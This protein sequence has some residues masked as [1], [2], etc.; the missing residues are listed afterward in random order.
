M[1]QELV[2][3]TPAD[4]SSYPRRVLL[5]VSGL[6]PQIVTETLYA[7]ATQSPTPW[8]PTEIHLLTTT[9]GAHRARLS[10]LSDDLGWF[11]RLCRDYGLQGITF[12]TDHIHVLQ[13]A[14]GEAMEDIR[15]VQDNSAAADAITAQVRAFSA[16]T[17]S[18]LHVSIAGG[19]K[20]MGF[21]AGYALSLF[22]RPQDR[23]SHVLVSEP[24]ENTLDFFYPT[25]YSR[26]LQTLNGRYADTREAQVTLAHIPFVSLR[27]GLPDA[28]LQGSATFNETVD[29]ARMALA[30]PKLSI[31]IRNRA[32]EAGGRKVR[33][34]PASLAM[35]ALFARRAMQQLPPIAAPHKEVPDME[36][37]EH[38]LPDFLRCS[39]G[40]FA[41]AEATK[42][43]LKH[44]MDGRW[45]STNLTRL[46]KT[47]KKALGPA[48]AAYCIDDGGSR[49]RR[50]SLRLPGNSISFSD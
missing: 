41:S 6:S 30:P 5:A 36:W 17:Q 28:L 24:F 8:V 11:H 40:D 42:Q 13:T 7:L 4:P 48:A 32:I 33:L 14:S 46:H 10:L 18:A 23:L 20:S 22:G 45:F 29:A 1:Q 12:N 25:P 15:T 37:A 27:H 49:P 21:Y 9:E 19:R 2:T 47:L 50:Y 39:G 31:S 35:L 16:D 44:G 3:G 26:T 34:S 38:Y 43:A